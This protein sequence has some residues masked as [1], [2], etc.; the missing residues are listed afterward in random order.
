MSGFIGIFNADGA[1]VD[2]G[3]LERLTRSLTFRGP[4]A[5][6]VWCQGSLGFGH[7]LFRTTREAVYE[8]QPFTLDQQVWIVADAR[9]DAREDLVRELACEH[10]IALNRT[11]DV[12]LI[13]RAYL[14]WGETCLDHMIG[15]FSFAICDVRSQRLFCARDHFGVKLFYYAWIG[16]TFIFSNTIAALRLHPEVTNRLN[17]RAIGDFFLFDCNWTLDSTFFAD[18]QKLPAAHELTV[19]DTGL[20]R[21]KY[22][23]LV[24]PERVSFRREEEYVE[25]FRERLDQAVAD[26]LR[27]EKVAI[28]F[29]GGLD[30]TN[31]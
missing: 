1:P 25:G 29:S 4:D 24:A 30:S 3:L 31:M 9:V 17:E 13:L 10:D 16:A 23:Q 28:S 12:E 14:K 18:I 7:T 6:A 8:R 22:W 21:R 2:S 5:H 26:R 19:V 20:K 27:T 11:P 15:D